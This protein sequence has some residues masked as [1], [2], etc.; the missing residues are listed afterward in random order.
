MIINTLVAQNEAKIS[1][2]ILH[3]DLYPYDIM[4]HKIGLTDLSSM[5]NDA[6][7]GLLAQT[8]A[9]RLLTLFLLEKATTVGDN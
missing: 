7:G 5:S 8:P 2:W 9:L 1:A 4:W 3:T 6:E